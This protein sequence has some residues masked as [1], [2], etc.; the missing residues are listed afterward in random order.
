M[1]PFSIHSEYIIHENIQRSIPHQL[2]LESWSG[3][4]ICALFCISRII[5]G[6]ND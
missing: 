3:T 5:G 1:S 6:L 2:S 4:W